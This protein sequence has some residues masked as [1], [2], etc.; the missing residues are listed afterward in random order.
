[1]KITMSAYR[2][3]SEIAQMSLDDWRRFMSAFLTCNP[4][5]GEAWDILT[6]LR[7]PD[8]PSERPDM[9]SKEAAEAY[10]GRRKRKY[11]TVEVIRHA[12]FFGASGGCARH[13]KGDV[14]KLPPRQQWDHFD[15]HVAR[16]A[17]ALGLKVDAQDR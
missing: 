16:A 9:A 2:E 4:H 14:V 6:C 7:G 3:P 15:K 5:S 10:A 17:N 13:H 8:A 11:D 12:A 1:M